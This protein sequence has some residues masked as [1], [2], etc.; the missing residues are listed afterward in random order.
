[1]AISRKR[2][3]QLLI[4]VGAALIA[5]GVGYIFISFQ[6]SAE[7]GLS[8]WAQVS[9]FFVGGGACGCW[10]I[11]SDKDYDSSSNSATSKPDRDTDTDAV[12]HLADRLRDHPHGLK[13]CR[14]LADCMFSVHHGCSRP[15]TPASTPSDGPDQPDIEGTLI[16]EGL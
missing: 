15:V 13:L 4:A 7:R 16:S 11:I 14:E 12:R 6:L 2:V 9:L 10:G 8:W 3:A 1:M 5:V